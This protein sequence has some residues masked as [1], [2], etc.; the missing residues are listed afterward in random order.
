MP[1]APASGRGHRRG[2]DPETLDHVFE[3]FFTTKDRAGT[4]LGLATVYGIVTQSGG[5]IAVESH[6]GAGALPG[7]L[8]LAEGVTEVCP[9]PRGRWRA[10]PG[11]PGE[12]AGRRGR[13]G[14]A[15]LAQEIL[16]EAGYRVLA[17]TPARSPWRWPL[18]RRGGG[19][20]GQRRGDAGMRGPDLAARLAEAPPGF[21]VVLMPRYA[22]DDLARRVGTPALLA[23]PSTPEA[24]LETGRGPRRPPARG[25]G[26]RRR[27]ALTRWGLGGPEGWATWPRSTA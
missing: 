8:P 6:A 4:G 20:V 9:Q 23:K 21:P 24:L 15:P 13:R 17:V 16:E 12:P 11:G 25:S 3:P 19:P 7:E 5:E 10:R 26:G 1:A 14:G 22:N 27:Y 18:P 2:D